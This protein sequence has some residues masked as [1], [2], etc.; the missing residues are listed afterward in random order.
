MRDGETP[1]RRSP[2]IRDTTYL[3]IYPDRPAFL[4][5]CGSLP[6]NLEPAQKRGDAHFPTGQSVHHHHAQLV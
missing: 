1:Q 2:G 3:G 4:G 6:Q 5:F